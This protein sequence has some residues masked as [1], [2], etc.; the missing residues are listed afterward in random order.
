MKILLLDIET[1]P[2]IAHVW[3]LWQQNIALNQLLDSGYVLCWSAKWLGDD[4]IMFSSVKR[5]GAKKMLK[6]AHRLLDECDVVV[7]FNGRSFDVPTLNKEF[8]ERGIL[9]PAPYK[10]ID[11]CLISRS[12]FRFPSNKLSYIARALK[13]QEKKSHR[14]HELWV[15]CMNNDRECWEEMEEY[16]KGDVITL[17]QVYMKMRPWIRNHPSAVVHDDIE[18]RAC[19]T[20]GSDNLQRRGYAATAQNKYPRYQCRDCGVWSRGTNLLQKPKRTRGIP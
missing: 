4:E 12:T 18:G 3:G 6:R 8:L 9:P 19:P 2:N 11:L 10:Q 17:E 13:V 7:H 5:D 20:C 15:G 14:G 16:N 1:A